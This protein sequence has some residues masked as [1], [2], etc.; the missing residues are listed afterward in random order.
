MLASKEDSCSI[1]KSV[2]I[3]RVRSRLW[4][5]TYFCKS[6]LP[7]HITLGRIKLVKLRILN[8]LFDNIFRPEQNYV[9][10]VQLKWSVFIVL[11]SV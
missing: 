7:D 5:D 9:A 6:Q 4:M 2:V 3:L 10:Y 8:F 11:F 1:P